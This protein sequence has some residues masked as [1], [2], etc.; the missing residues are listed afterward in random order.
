MSAGQYFS[1][2]TLNE[3]GRRNIEGIAS[4]SFHC[5][6]IDIALSLHCAHSGCPLTLSLCAVLHHSLPLSADLRAGVTAC[7]SGAACLLHLVQLQHEQALTDEAE[8][9]GKVSEKGKTR[10]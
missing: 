9:E 3:Q 8:R 2:P 7:L 1:E 5:H 10:Q 6:F 4:L